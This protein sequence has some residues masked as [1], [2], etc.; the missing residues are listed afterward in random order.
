MNALLNI[1]PLAG[2]FDER[3]ERVA[4]GPVLNRLAAY[5]SSGLTLCR[6]QILRFPSAARS[7][8]GPVEVADF[9]SDACESHPRPHE[10]A[11]KGCGITNAWVGKPLIPTLGMAL[12]V[13]ERTIGCVGTGFL[14]LVSAFFFGGHHFPG[15]IHE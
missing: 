15:G 5:I 14:A 4:S 13:L 6:T 3:I 2:R 10:S 8:H 12:G 1:S 7:S 11:L 9:R